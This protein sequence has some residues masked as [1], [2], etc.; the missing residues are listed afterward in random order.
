MA[1]TVN[2]VALAKI[3][4]PAK[5]PT[6]ILSNRV[7]HQTQTLNQIKMGQHQAAQ[8][9]NQIKMVNQAVNQ[10]PITILHK[11]VQAHKAKTKV[12]DKIHKVIIDVVFQNLQ[13]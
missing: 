2:Q 1:K 4:N 9:H 6:I 7:L 11:Q 5:I 3:V 8:I 13:F 12:M 10:I